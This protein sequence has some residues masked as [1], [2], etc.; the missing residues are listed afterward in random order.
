[1]WHKMI[2]ICSLFL[3]LIWSLEFYTQFIKLVAAYVTMGGWASLAAGGAMIGL[4]AA[5]SGAILD[6]SI[7]AIAAAA[8]LGLRIWNVID[9]LGTSGTLS[10][11]QPY[12]RFWLYLDLVGG[13]T[14]PKDCLETQ[15][16]GLEKTLT[17]SF[18]E[19]NLLRA[20]P[21]PQ[22]YFSR[23]LGHGEF[24]CMIPTHSHE[25]IFTNTPPPGRCDWHELD[26]RD[27]ARPGVC[28]PPGGV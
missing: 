4:S 19:Q 6:M 12:A 23:N 18:L 7:V 2:G 17:R 10:R 16:I 11:A 3:F 26:L 1:M 22:I 9:L 13:S 5:A 21:P 20:P 24:L 8:A 14:I 28:V 15:K 25:N 27:L